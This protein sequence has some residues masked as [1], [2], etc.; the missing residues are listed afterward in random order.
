MVKLI[1]SK[2]KMMVTRGWGEG[3]WGVKKSIGIRF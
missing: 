1:G 2:S 3:K